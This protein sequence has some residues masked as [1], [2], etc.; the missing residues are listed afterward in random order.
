MPRVVSALVIL[1]VPV[2]M[3]ACATPYRISPKYNA[4]DCFVS[5]DVE[6]WEQAYQFQVI[7]V[8]KHS[9]HVKS[10]LVDGSFLIA[11]QHKTRPVPCSINEIIDSRLRDTL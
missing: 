7:E 10:S 5:T 11:E 8:G 1:S 6:Q 2:V 9:Y 3:A 4:G